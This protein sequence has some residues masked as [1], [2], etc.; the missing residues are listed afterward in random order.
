M[1]E[2]TLIQGRYRLLGLVGRG[3]MG[4]VWRAH[5]E[6]L[7]REVAVKCLKPPGSRP[8][9][10]ETVALRERFRRE[11]RLAASLQHRGVTVV[12]DFGEHDGVLYLVME[13]LDGHDLSRLLE[14]GGR[15]PLPVPDLFDI[16]EQ[17]AAALAYTHDRGIVHRDLKPANVVRTADGTVK[18]CDFGIARLDRG[19]GPAAGTAGGFPMGTPHYMSPEQITGA[20]LDHRSDLYSLGCVLY[21]IATGTPPFDLEDTWGVLVGHRETA[22]RPPRELRPDLPGDLERIILDLLAKEP[23]GRPG[24]AAELG[25]RT[26]EARRAGSPDGRRTPLRQSPGSAERLPEWAYGVRT[27]ARAVAGRPPRSGPSVFPGSGYPGVLSGPWTGSGAG[28]GAGRGVPD[29]P[30]GE[31]PA[32]ARRPRSPAGAAPD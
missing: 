18:I 13:L 2:S 1:R 14:L 7:D 10:Q 25:R 8:G 32:A 23:D 17:M 9:P 21:E 22:P 26:A 20:H 4:Q 27:G 31:D 12:H 29:A 19:T 24:D 6:S 30:G 28:A 15:R 11:A 16:A 5:D 3:G